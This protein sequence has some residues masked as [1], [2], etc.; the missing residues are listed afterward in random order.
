MSDPGRDEPDRDDPAS[1]DPAR[2]LA[3]LHAARGLMRDAAG[4]APGDAAGGVQLGEEP[5]RPGLAAL[6]AHAT[7]APGAPVDLAVVRALRGDPAAQR[8]YRALLA[9]QAVAHAPFAVAASDGGLAA[10]RVGAYVLELVPAEDGSPPLLVIRGGSGRAIAAIEASLGDAAVRLALPAPVE[11]A[12]LLALDPA[13]PEADR[14]GRL[15]ADPA[16]AVFLL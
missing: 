4:R 8:R 1:R 6:W 13:L 11:G 2:L 7:R 15:L 10:R 5:A 14:L 3:E 9:G 12:Y 16:A